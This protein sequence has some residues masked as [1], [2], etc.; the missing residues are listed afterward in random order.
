MVDP[1]EMDALFAGL[2]AAYIAC[3]GEQWTDYGDVKTF[4]AVAAPIWGMQAWPVACSS[5]IQSTHGRSS[6]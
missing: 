6:P 4:S 1:G 3:D 5:V 2:E